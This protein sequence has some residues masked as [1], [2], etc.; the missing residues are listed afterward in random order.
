MDGHRRGNDVTRRAPRKEVKSYF[1]ALIFL[2]DQSLYPLQLVVPGLLI[3]GQSQISM[4]SM[5]SEQY[6]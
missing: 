6:A 1:N 4:T 2:N 3:M 5:T